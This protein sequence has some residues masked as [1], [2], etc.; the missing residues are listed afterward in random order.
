MDGAGPIAQFIHITLPH[1]S[2]AISVVVMI[3][4][5]FL[6]TVFAEIFVTT[7]GRPGQ[8]PRPISPF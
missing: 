8:T 1:L 7:A 5:I 6:L 4:T 3:E 2:R